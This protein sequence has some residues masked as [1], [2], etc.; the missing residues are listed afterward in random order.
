MLV[1]VG[2]H[3]GVM[4]GTAGGGLRRRMNAELARAGKAAGKRLE[5]DAVEREVLS[6]AAAIADRAEQLQA[7]FE[8]SLAEADVGLAV[9]LS[10]ELRLADRAVTE[11]VSK[12]NPGLQPKKS[13]RHQRAAHARW[14]VSV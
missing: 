4:A 5:W 11:L 8:T 2:C 1:G 13:E 10:A 6:R 3:A 12:L 9:K 14:G 7:A